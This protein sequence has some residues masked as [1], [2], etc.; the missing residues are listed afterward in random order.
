MGRVQRAISLC[1]RAV[2]LCAELG[3]QVGEAAAWDSL[4]LC[5]RRLADYPAAIAC[6]RRSVELTGLIGDRYH[7]ADALVRIGDTYQAAAD[8]P[9]ARG[10]WQQA[11]L[12]LDELRHPD[13]HDVR[14][15][16]ADA[17]QA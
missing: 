2:T 13:V 14:R 12:I 3:D 15:K 9:A 5:H 6:S 11:M 10:A 4:G 8:L 16:L 7:Q 1:E 17:H